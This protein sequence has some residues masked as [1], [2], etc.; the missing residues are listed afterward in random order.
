MADDNT[1]PVSARIEEFFG[2]GKCWV[3]YQTGP[4]EGPG[5]WLYKGYCLP[6]QWE[7][8]ATNLEDIQAVGREHKAE[9][10][11]FEIEEF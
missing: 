11:G 5:S 8:Y 6:H 9:W 2:P 3:V 4:W 10:D 7:D 1:D